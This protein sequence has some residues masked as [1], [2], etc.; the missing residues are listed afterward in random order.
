MRFI[1]KGKGSPRAWK[2]EKGPS[3]QAGRTA[4]SPRETQSRTQTAGQHRPARAIPGSRG[5]PVQ[6]GDGKGL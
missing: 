1:A 2:S 5:K 3:G 4:E 6:R